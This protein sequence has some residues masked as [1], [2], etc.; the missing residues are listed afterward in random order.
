MR[1]LKDP[2]RPGLGVL[3]EHRLD[4][5]LRERMVSGKLAEYQTDDEPLDY[6][7]VIELI[8]GDL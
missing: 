2:M 3:V 4:E 7:A 6:L 8:E 5:A 1:K